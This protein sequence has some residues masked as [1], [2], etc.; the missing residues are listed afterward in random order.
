MGIATKKNALTVEMRSLTFPA[1]EAVMSAHG[2]E[3]KMAKNWAIKT[4]EIVRGSR[5]LMTPETG[6]WP[7][8]LKVT[9]K[10]PCTKS[11][12]HSP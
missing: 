3:T 2:I 10:S 9:P 6:G 7:V 4:K 1:R 5:S 8:E 12:T 11:L